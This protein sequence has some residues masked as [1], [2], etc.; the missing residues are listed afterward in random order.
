ME[1]MSVKKT[2]QMGKFWRKCGMQSFPENILIN[3]RPPSI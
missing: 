1:R 3:Y 2:N